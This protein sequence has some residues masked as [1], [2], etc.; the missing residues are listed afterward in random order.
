MRTINVYANGEKQM[1]IYKESCG[2]VTEQ[3]NLYLCSIS[4][5]IYLYVYIHIQ[6]EKSINK[7]GRRHVEIVG[8]TGDVTAGINTP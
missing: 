4:I 3:V 2:T 7:Y 6:R 8:I 5:Y 1:G